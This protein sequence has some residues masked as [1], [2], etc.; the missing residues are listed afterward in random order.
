MKRFIPIALLALGF[1][2]PAPA[3]GQ[4]PGEVSYQGLLTGIT[5]TVDLTM[6]LYATP[7]GG[8]VLWTENHPGVELDANGVFSVILGSVQ[9][10]NGVTFERPYWLE[11]AVNGTI[12]SPRTGLA[13]APYAFRARTANGVANGSIEPDDL[14]STGAAPVD[15]QVP[16]F[17]AAS[18]QFRWI[19]LGG[20]GGGGI[21]QLIEGDG[22]RITGL[23][24]PVS[25]ISVADGGVTT[26]MLADGAVTGGKIASETIVSAN[27]ADGAITQDKF[28]NDVGLPNIGAA[29]GD[30]TGNYPN[31]TL[32]NDVVGAPNL[33]TGAVTTVKIEDDAVTSDKIVDG[34]VNSEHV[35]ALANISITTLR[36]SDSVGTPKLT[37]KGNSTLDGSVGIGT[38]PVNTRRL[39]IKGSGATTATGSIEVV[40][41][42][43]TPIFMVRDDGNVGVG[44]NAPSASLEIR[45]PGGPGLNVSSGSTSFSVGSV[46]A[47]PAIA[48]P[49]NT[50]IVMINPD[51][52]PGSPNVLTMPA[53]TL[54]GEFLIIINNDNDPT[55]GPAVILAGQA[56]IFTFLPAP[57]NAWRRVN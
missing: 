55:A 22:I 35:N 21:S 2:A 12:L 20:G 16:G 23:T 53:A 52:A 28:A 10:L 32:A 48:V 43:N 14:K 57:V 49:A 17:D 47:G 8:T 36:A 4:V 6:R 54:P 45:A 37:V 18:G 41:N 56:G 38:A 11:V 15:M 34:A 40:D 3:F 46:A 42:A 44:T 33:K 9:P 19:T 7:V 1:C 51:G 24:G 50:T 30:L 27:I 39:M 13:A 31:P 26:A 29:G 5:G 25:T